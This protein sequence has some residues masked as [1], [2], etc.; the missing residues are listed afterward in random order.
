MSHIVRRTLWLQRSLPVYDA[1]PSF[2]KTRMSWF[3]TNLIS[4]FLLPPLSLLIVAGIGLWLWHKRPF[5]ARALVTLAFA[6]LWLL[7][8]PYISDA[9]MHSLEGEPYVTDTQK[10]LADAIVVLGGGTYFHAP[11]YGGDTINHATLERLRFAAKLH[12]ETGK[13]IL[14]T[15]GKPL[16]NTTSEATQMRKVLEKEF[17]VSV[18]WVEDESD[19]TFENARMSSVTLKGADI[20]RI[21]LVTHA[22]HMPRAVQAFQSTGLQVIPAP[23][24]YTTRYA[25]TLLTFIPRAEA[26]LDSRRYF[27][28][29]IGML[30]YQL[31]S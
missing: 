17:N 27:H 22:W 16:G 18:K 9:L 14:V 5:P 29:R 11:E 24:G 25:T 1:Q 19:N 12:R 2:A 4:P 10:P 20:T 28:E 8:T 15:G 23:T 3:I 30:W 31:K 26:L 13:P 7:S 21:Y 6:G